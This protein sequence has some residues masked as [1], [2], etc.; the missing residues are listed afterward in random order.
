MTMGS[1]FQYQNAN[2][3]FKNLDKLIKYVNQQ[4]SCIHSSKTDQQYFFLQQINGSNVNVFYSTPSC[5]LYALN[6]ANRTWTSKID[7]FFPYAMGPHLVRTGFYTSRPALKRYERYSNNILQ[8]TRQLNAFAQLNMR[9]NMFPLGKIPLD[10]LSSQFFI[11][12]SGC[13]GYFATS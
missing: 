3:W 13:H 12:H 11:F 10:I 6:R 9:N 8:V 4:V 1:D 5:Y 2:H 7:D